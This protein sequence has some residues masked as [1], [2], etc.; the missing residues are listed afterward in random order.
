M[1]KHNITNLFPGTEGQYWRSYDCS[2]GS[3]RG[4]T[5]GLGFYVTMRCMCVCVCCSV[6]NQRGVNA[7]TMFR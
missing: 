3:Y 2:S 7:A 4:V 6:E 1:H 5:E